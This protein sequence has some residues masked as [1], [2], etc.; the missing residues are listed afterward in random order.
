[1]VARDF[2]QQEVIRRLHYTHL[3]NLHTDF[4]TMCLKLLFLLHCDHHHYHTYHLQ[5]TGL[6]SVPE[7]S[8][9]PSYLQMRLWTQE[10]LLTRWG[11]SASKIYLKVT[12]AK[13]RLSQEG[14]NWHFPPTVLI[15]TLSRFP[16]E[17]E[18]LKSRGRDTLTT[19]TSVMLI[20]FLLPDIR[21]V[22]KT[23]PT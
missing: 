10:S 5:H 22:T 2:P 19:P 23:Q 16:H 21:D 8:V 13:L 3:T 20:V 4:L 7:H 11:N 14:N 17:L 9:C 18:L 1:M 15:Y 12:S 6:P